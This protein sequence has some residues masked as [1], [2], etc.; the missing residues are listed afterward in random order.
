MTLTSTKFHTSSKVFRLL[1]KVVSR[2]ANHNDILQLID[3]SIELFVR[4][5]RE[6]GLVKSI[7]YFKRSRLHVT[8]FLSGNPLLEVEGVK[9][10]SDGLP[11]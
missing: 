11:K 8:R 3:K 5:T 1:R 2:E 9:I 10:T 4:L 6:R 7:A